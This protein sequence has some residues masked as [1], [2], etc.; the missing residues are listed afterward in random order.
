MDSSDL[1]PSSGDVQVF[2]ISQGL[3]SNFSNIEELEAEQQKLNDEISSFKIEQA[4]YVIENQDLR[5]EI[6]SYNVR[7]ESLVFELQ[8][9]GRQKNNAK[10]DNSELN[11]KI[12]S[13][14][15][16]LYE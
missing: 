8:Q 6:A 14:E 15:E 1:V 4:A 11:E 3:E 10:D 13:L 5:Q 12:I 7:I 9:T 16:E 2:A